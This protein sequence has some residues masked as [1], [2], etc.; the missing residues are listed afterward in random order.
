MYFVIRRRIKTNKN[1]EL[2]RIRIRNRRTVNERN[3]VDKGEKREKQRK[4]KPKLTF[5]N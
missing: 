1:V 3:K 4:R 2:I 5:I